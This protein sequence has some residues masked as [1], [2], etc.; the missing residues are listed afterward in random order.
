[1]AFK[2][3][4]I[5]PHELRS[6]NSVQVH[7]QPLFILTIRFHS[8]TFFINHFFTRF[9]IQSQVRKIIVCRQFF[10]NVQG[11][12]AK[13]THLEGQTTSFQVKN[14][15]FGLKIPFFGQNL[16]FK[17]KTSFEN[18]SIF[19]SKSSS[20]KVIFGHFRHTF[21]KLPCSAYLFHQLLA[22]CCEKRMQVPVFD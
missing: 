6:Q 13:M 2:T 7:F 8:S 22:F 12:F 16:V 10:K 14:P 11:G 20:F 5:L 17:S 21:A 15:A 19:G 18:N 4:P 9:T 3:R 1:M